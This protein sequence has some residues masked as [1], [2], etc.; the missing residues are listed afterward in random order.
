[1]V[2]KR[3]Q[4]EKDK[5]HMISLIC[6]IQKQPKMKQMNKTNENQHIDTENRV[7]VTRGNYIYLYDMASLDSVS[8]DNDSDS[9]SVESY[10]LWPHGL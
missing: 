2:S 9:R 4:M 5:Y 6:G 10:S 8:L 7:V 3:N 1:M